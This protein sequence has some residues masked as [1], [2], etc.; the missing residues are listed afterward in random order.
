[1]FKKSFVEIR[2]DFQVLFVIFDANCLSMT[3]KKDFDW[4]KLKNWNLIFILEERVNERILYVYWIK[5]FK[6]TYVIRNL[7]KHDI[8]IWKTINLHE[9]EL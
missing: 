1:M 6:W 8:N 7:W 5:T 9:H 2:R 4:N 3:V